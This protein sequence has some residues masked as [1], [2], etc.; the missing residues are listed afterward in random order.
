MYL[1]AANNLD[2]VDNIDTA[3]RTL[4]VYRSRAE[5]LMSSPAVAPSYLRTAGYSVPGDLGRS[6]FIRN[7]TSTGDLVLALDDGLTNVGYDRLRELIFTPRMFG[8]DPADTPSNQRAALQTMCDLAPEG[9]VLDLGAMKFTIDNSIVLRRGQIIRNGTLELPSSVTTTIWGMLCAADDS[10]IENLTLVGPGLV[11]SGANPL[12]QVGI[13]SGSMS[14]FGR[15][16]ARRVHV[17]DCDISNLTVGIFLQPDTTDPVPSQWWIERNYIH[18]IVG[19]AGLSEG[20]GI[21][22]GYGADI[23]AAYNTLRNIKRHAIYYAGVDGGQI[24]GNLINGVDNIAIQFNGYSNQPS[25]YGNI[26]AFNRI[27]NVTRSIDY[28]YLSSVGIGIYGKQAFTE[29]IGNSIIGVLQIGI[30]AGGQSNDAIVT[31]SR[32]FICSNDISVDPNATAGAGIQISNFPSTTVQGNNIRLASAIFGI[33]C[34]VSANV[35]G[36]PICVNGN[37]VITT[38]TSATLLRTNVTNAG[39]N[40]QAFSNHYVGFSNLWMDSSTAGIVRSDLNRGIAYVSTDAN[41]VHISCGPGLVDRPNIRLAE[42]RTATRSVV[43]STSEVPIGMT[44]RVVNRTSGGYPQQIYSGSVLVSLSSG[45]QALC[46]W[47]GVAWELLEKG[48]A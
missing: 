45:E 44:V 21:A 34:A 24:V 14:K 25:S 3:V 47:N 6:D 40:I 26:I 13:S 22:V 38:N 31:G 32:L 43:L 9:A 1:L 2:D 42:A 27:A 16:P 28:G 5:A 10:I 12:Y 20:Y 46:G 39:G 19:L 11:G 15:N 23:V 18:D 33:S 48:G 37:T 17:R 35:S 36:W 4:G 7:G 29:V 30:D 41:V 8:A